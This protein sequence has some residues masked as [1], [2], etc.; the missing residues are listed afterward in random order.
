[1]YTQMRLGRELASEITR[2]WVEYCESLEALPS[3]TIDRLLGT[4]QS[5][6]LQLHG[7]CDPSTRAYA[8]AVYLRVAN[9][10]RSVGIH[11][12]ASKS[13][14][15]PIKTISIP[16]LELCGVVLLV[17]LV[18]CL[19]KLALY[20]KLSILLWSDSQIVLAWLNKHPLH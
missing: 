7:F 3:I 4:S 10:N 13:K 11:L 17:Q 19:R 8:T 14:V 9:S 16:N 12:I 20:E 5:Q 2:R 15:A 1:M 18:I 6:N